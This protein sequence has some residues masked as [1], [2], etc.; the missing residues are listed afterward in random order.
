MVRKGCD[1]EIYNEPACRERSVSQVARGSVHLAF[2]SKGELWRDCGMV[3]PPI[4]SRVHYSHG[5]KHDRYDRWRTLIFP[6]SVLAL[7]ATQQGLHHGLQMMEDAMKLGEANISKL[8]KPSSYTSMPTSSQQQSKPAVIPKRT[9]ATDFKSIAE[10]HAQAHDLM[11]MPTGRVHVK[12]RLPMYRVTGRGDGK[13]GI[14]VY[15]LD[16]AVWLV[17]G[18]KEDGESRAIALREMVLLASKA[19]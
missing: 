4:F 18:G 15:V 8:P 10:E 19:S 14:V 5:C 7:D 6:E 17:E 1:R 16:D 2:A 9:A 13:G 3:R 11:F 12:V